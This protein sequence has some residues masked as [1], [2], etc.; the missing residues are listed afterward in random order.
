MKILFIIQVKEGQIPVSGPVIIFGAPPLVTSV[1]QPPAAVGINQIQE[2]NHNP[3][4]VKE[5]GGFLPASSP[6]L[7]KLLE[8]NAGEVFGCKVCGRKLSSANSLKRHMRIHTGE[9]FPCSLCSKTFISP[10]EVNRHV[11]VK[12]DNQQQ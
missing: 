1:Q 5:T 12:H 8:L 3:Y 2:G 9:R 6:T 7:D 11:K 10:A 4:P